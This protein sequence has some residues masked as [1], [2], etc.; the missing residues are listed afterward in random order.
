MNWKMNIDIFSLRTVGSDSLYS[1]RY[2]HLWVLMC[3]GVGVV[4]YEWMYVLIP[5]NECEENCILH[6]LFFLYLLLIFSLSKVCLSLPYILVKF[7]NVVSIWSIKEVYYALPKCKLLTF[8]CFIKEY[9][10]SFI[11]KLDFLHCHLLDNTLGLPNC[12]WLK[13]HCIMLL[14]LQTQIPWSTTWALNAQISF[15]CVFQCIRRWQR[16]Y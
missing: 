5:V 15:Y 6:Y 13:F 7:A 16:I 10:G 12:C 11:L 3:V 4:Y 2:A 9:W 1:C 14:S 8:S